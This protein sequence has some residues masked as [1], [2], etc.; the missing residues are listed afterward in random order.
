MC[1]EKTK[2]MHVPE[3]FEKE[4]IID[5]VN[6]ILDYLA[7]NFTF[8][9]FDDD[10]MKQEGFIFAME[11]LPR[12]NAGYG[13]SLKT[14]LSRH[15]TNRFLNM[16]RNKLYR[17]TPPCFDCKH[18]R[19]NNC[20]K[21]ERQQYCSKWHRWNYRNESKKS[22]MEFSNGKSANDEEETFE[23]DIPSLIDGKELLNYVSKRIKLSDRADFCRFIEG[24]K[25][26]KSRKREIVFIIKEIASDIVEEEMD[27]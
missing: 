4:E 13:C 27:D 23:H 22:L 2:N 15:I 14:F 17:Y 20:K 7:P 18:Y 1:V 10:D 24:A 11:A 21:Y 9:Y 19:D 26:P 25:L 16:V 8:G 3:E 6:D 5:I 12:F